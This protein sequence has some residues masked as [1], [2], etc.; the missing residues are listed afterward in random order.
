VPRDPDLDDE[1]E[2][3]ANSSEVQLLRAVAEAP[4]ADA[5]KML[6]HIHPDLADTLDATPTHDPST[7]R[8]GD[9]I[10]ERYRIEEV[11]GAGGMGIVFGA[12]HVSTG[13]KVALK[14]MLS[15]GLPRSS[16][17]RESASQ[18][19]VREA[20]A[21]GRIRHDNVVDVYDAGTDKDAPYLVMERLEGETLRARMERGPMAWD[22][23]LSLLLPIMHGVSAAHREGVVHRDL[24]PDNVFLANTT[25]GQM[26]P[27]VLDFGISRLRVP[28]ASE[29]SLTRT[30]TMIGT[31]AYMPLEQLRGEGNIDERVD[32]Y[33]LGVVLY[34]MLTGSRP[35]VA[36]NAA[37]FAAL[38]A[39]A[40]PV[41][42]STHR[43]EL[44]GAREAAV[45]KALARS[46]ADRFASVDSLAEALV[47]AAMPASGKRARSLL[48]FAVLA[49]CL[50]LVA[51][52]AGR[53]NMAATVERANAP[54][55]AREPAPSTQP[56]SAQPE[57]AAAPQQQV[58]LP[59]PQPT[60][61]AAAQP[62][63]P[64]ARAGQAAKAK[65][66][67]KPVHSAPSESSPSRLSP[68]DFTKPASSGPS[69]APETRAK[70]PSL[71]LGREEF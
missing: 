13:R 56:S 34:E 18:R 36:R 2:D 14:W 25:S 50:A 35:Y 1:L 65:Q 71:D 19:F 31:P 12:L 23:A 9:V 41:A 10:D 55:L 4:R 70:P 54:T 27:K 40:Q 29:P 53:T 11:L 6:G 62:N 24:K 30:G 69:V 28:D 33:A 22:E 49:V 39:S 51:L 48:L 46:P 66:A 44:R 15:R 67:R 45:M 58:L 32:V 68:E 60:P 63:P 20:Q 26:V 52:W 17:E 61:P 43:P 64:S 47:G 3:F 38:I 21:T 37:D 5:R 8:I 57:S 7:P 59:T 42:L 16:R